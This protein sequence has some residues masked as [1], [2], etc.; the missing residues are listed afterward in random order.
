[1]APSLNWG[2]WLSSGYTFYR[3]IPFVG[4]VSRG[5]DDFYATYSPWRTWT[6]SWSLQYHSVY[7]AWS[8]IYEPIFMTLLILSKPDLY[9]RPYQNYTS[10]DIIYCPSKERTAGF[11]PFIFRSHSVYVNKMLFDH[12]FSLSFHQRDKCMCWH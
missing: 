3:L 1:M 11:G 8:L 5:K 6:T 4:F 7:T 9:A 10:Y 2:L 12:L